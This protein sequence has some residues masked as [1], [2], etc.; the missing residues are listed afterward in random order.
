MM[1][2]VEEDTGLIVMPHSSVR[3]AWDILIFIG[4]FFY[5]ITYP[6]RLSVT[7]Y[8]DKN[9]LKAY[10]GTAPPDQWRP[11]LIIAYIFDFIFIV[12]IALKSTIFAYELDAATSQGQG[13]GV[14]D[15]AKIFAHYY[16]SPGFALEVVTAFPIDFIGVVSPSAL[17]ALRFW[18][19]LKGESSRRHKFLSF[20]TR[21]HHN[22]NVI[23]S[24][25]LQ[26]S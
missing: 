20:G 14:T 26:I 3:I 23:Q 25:T 13:S 11:A 19:Y 6:Y 8:F 5:A 21:T 15:P 4:Y 10:P 2:V 18:H 9:S 17:P 7:Y 22:Q 24:S 16:N 1:P 12:D